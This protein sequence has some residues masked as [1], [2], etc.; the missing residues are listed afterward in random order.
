MKYRRVCPETSDQP[1]RSFDRAEGRRVAPVV[2]AKRRCCGSW[3]E[4]APVVGAKRL[5]KPI[6]SHNNHSKITS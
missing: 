5:N 1:L 4:G 2:G 3:G 6:H